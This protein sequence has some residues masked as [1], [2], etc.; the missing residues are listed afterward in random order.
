MTTKGAT[1]LG[2]HAISARNSHNSR[3]LEPGSNIN[4]CGALAEMFEL[5]F[6]GRCEEEDF[7]DDSPLHQAGSAAMRFSS[8]EERKDDQDSID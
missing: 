4:E 2:R 1:S 6:F 5:F 8:K 7:T 3:H